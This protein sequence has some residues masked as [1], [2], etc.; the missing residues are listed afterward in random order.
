MR[1]NKATGDPP[2]PGG[3]GGGWG[4]KAKECQGVTN[5]TKAN[6]AIEWQTG[7]CLLATHTHTGTQTHPD[8]YKHKIH[9][10]I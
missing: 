7:H 3:W 9:T 2:F 4:Q 10:H 8:T 1:V 6:K 5:V